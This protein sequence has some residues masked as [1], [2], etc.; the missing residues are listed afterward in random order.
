MQRIWPFI[1]GINAPH[2]GWQENTK[3]LILMN[4]VIGR[5]SSLGVGICFFVGCGVQ[6]KNHKSCSSHFRPCFTTAMM[7]L[8]E[9]QCHTLINVPRCQAPTIPRGFPIVLNHTRL[10]DDGNGF[11]NKWGIM[12]R[13]REWRIFHQ[14]RKPSYMDAPLNLTNFDFMTYINPWTEKHME[15]VCAL[16]M[17]PN[18]CAVFQ[19]ALHPA[20]A[21]G[22]SRVSLSIMD[23]VEQ[24]IKELVPLT[25]EDFTCW[26][27]HRESPFHFGPRRWG[28]TSWCVTSWYG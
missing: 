11:R 14:A 21:A 12:E 22:Y 2:I 28:T 27:F 23:R 5:R 13:W 6:S 7:Y 4:M 8:C 17:F 1:W 15:N 18:P 10:A 24:V 9:S 20:V 3:L 19:G 25:C 26:G 16:K